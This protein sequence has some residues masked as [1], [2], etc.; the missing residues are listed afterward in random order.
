MTI[1][2]IRTLD[3]DMLHK[4]LTSVTIEA[5][6]AAP[7]AET[8]HVDTDTAMPITAPASGRP[9]QTVSAATPTPPQPRSRTRR[10]AWGVLKAL[11]PLAAI[12]AG[13]AGFKYL[14]ATRPETPKQPQAERTFAVE[15]VVARRASAQPML[16]L[17]GSTV[18]GRQVDIRALVA[19][20]VIETHQELREGGRIG[21]R[22]RLLTI[23]PFDYKSALDEAKAQR[24]ETAAR[25][26]E[27]EASLAAEKT[28]LTH[29]RAQLAI[30]E[31]DVTRAEQL[32]AR[33]NLSDRSLDDRRQVVLQ[34]RQAAD[35]LQSSIPVWEARIAQTRL[36]AERLDVAIE[37]AQKRLTE[38]RLE[39]PFDAFVTE[40]A[41]QVG[42]MVSVNDKVATLIDRSWI[43]AQF[44][45]T[46][47]QFGRITAKDG[48]LEGRKVV[49]R[50]KLGEETFAFDAVVTRVGARITSTTG[51]VDVF[52]RIATPE[53][54]VQIRPG[55]FVEL[56]V[57]DVSFDDVV[58]VPSTALYDRDT[59]FVVVDGRL[60]PR[61]VSLI[62]TAA[63]D[64]L[65]RG[66]L[67]DGERIVTSRLSTPG[68]GLAVT[69]AAA[70]TTAPAAKVP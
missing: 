54:P 56:E 63:G 41:A 8:R 30:A 35:Q 5:E 70:S 21:V 58:R 1:A 20:R 49:V 50:W 13:F 2:P 46:D 7:S 51:G 68:K 43:E 48:T 19:G 34:R 61:K 37:R 31:S 3:L 59:V 22:E 44:S 36:T 53:R 32:T 29:A 14:K 55:A 26:K 25:L 10:L 33:G 17:Y 45:L 64:I 42:R 23:D 47:S 60:D 38:T 24:S 4:R 6:G 40:V 11:L 66:P 16:R 27:Q 9:G 62:G 52:A 69:D 67:Q 39:A 28:S 57:P 12:A 65:I 18:A 15:T